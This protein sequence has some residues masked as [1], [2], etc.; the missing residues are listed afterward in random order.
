MP[1]QSVV[2]HDSDGPDDPEESG[3][4]SGG[5][6]QRLPHNTNRSPVSWCTLHANN[7]NCIYFLNSYGKHLYQ[8]ANKIAN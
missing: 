3:Y 4:R 2:I 1:H 8:I 6:G 7:H 5:N